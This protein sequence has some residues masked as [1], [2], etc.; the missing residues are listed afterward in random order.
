VE[1]FNEY[2]MVDSDGV[3][4]GG[5]VGQGGEEM[6]NYLT[7]YIEVPDINAHLERVGEAGGSTIMP[8]TEI[9]DTVTFALFADPAGNV[10]GL[11]E[12]D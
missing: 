4:L 1:G 3:G 12:S 9:P 7:L 11:V 2:H 5:A 6:P 10:V 8:R